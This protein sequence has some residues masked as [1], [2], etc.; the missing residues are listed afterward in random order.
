MPF[1]ERL[2]LVP[3]NGKRPVPLT[4]QRGT[5]RTINT[6]NDNADLGAW[7]LRSGLYLQSSGGVP[8]TSARIYRQAANQSITR[9]APPH[10][11]PDADQIVTALGARL[12]IDAPNGC[13]AEMDPTAA[14]SL[15]WYNPATHAEQWVLRAPADAAGVIGVV[16]YDSTENARPGSLGEGIRRPNRGRRS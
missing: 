14:T 5:G 15:L 12:L 6:A 10:T 7:R 16:A 8:C 4:P 11:N 3:T 9:V 2:W 13:L 1:G